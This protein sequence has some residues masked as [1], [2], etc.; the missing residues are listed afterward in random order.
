[1]LKWTSPGCS[2]RQYITS[3][4]DEKL[5]QAK[6][7]GVSDRTVE[8]C[9]EAQRMPDQYMEPELDDSPH[10]LIHGDLR[11]ANIVVDSDFNVQMYVEP[12]L[13]NYLT[14]IS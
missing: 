4:I 2:A 9:R 1:M 12:G 5:C 6:S 14:L 13:Q 7:H 11:A 10:V 8:E 3:K